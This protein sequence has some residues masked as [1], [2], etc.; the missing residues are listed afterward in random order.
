MIKIHNLGFPRIGE[1]RELKFALER[2]WRGELD[3]NELEQTAAELRARHWHTQANSGLDL[4]PVG[5]FSY[6]DH[7]LD[8]SIMLGVIP[9][10]F[11]INADIDTYFRMARG[12]G[13]DN[14]PYRALEMTKWFDTNYH[15]LVPEITAH[16]SFT[17]S[18]NKLFDET[19]EL[20]TLGY[21]A[22]P[23]L[24]GPLTW[25]WLAKAP[26]D[27]NKLDLLAKLLPVYSE[28]LCRLAEQGVQWVQIDE[29]ILV[30]DLPAAWK[31]AFEAVYNHLQSTPIKLL[32][33][34]YFGGV[35]ELTSFVCK[36]PVAGLHI[37]CI[38]AP[39][40]L[41]GVL[42]NLANHKVL[43][44][45]VIDGRN[46]WRTDLSS[47][48]NILES[49]KQRF[50]GELWLAPSCSLL[51][52]PIDLEYETALNPT[53]KYW[54][55]FAKQKLTEL[56]VLRNAVAEPSAAEADLIASACAIQSRRES[57]LSHNPA[58]QAELAKINN[59]LTQRQ[60]PFSVRRQQ[61]HAKLNL[62]SYPTTTIGSFPQ[63]PDIRKAR[64]DFKRGLLSETDYI[65]QMQHSIEFCI[66]EQEQLG[67][68]VLVHGEAERNDMVEYFGEQLEGFA[69]TVN[70][71]V[72]SY[73][74]RCVKPPIIYGDVS[75][76]K[77]ITVRWSQYAQSLT[78]KPMKGMLTGPVTLLNWS[79]CS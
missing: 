31:N 21:Q 72:Q 60:S 74:S 47:V 28:I 12:Q 53:I 44:L 9:E 29:P 62:P 4:I 67:L 23:V 34:T 27:V 41:T 37:D 13:R 71:W 70:G 49:V 61:Q 79:F 56:A 57:S 73:G 69:F 54:L 75:R 58:V 52:V 22:K 8:T 14:Q 10:R 66:R 35:D 36:L 30:L 43:S 17:L 65:Q 25:L 40:Q 1:H 7:V 3:Q 39:G 15:Y 45:G 64:A 51:H 18:S 19:R 46:I 26:D 59:S 50:T 2:Y 42:D 11:G 38:R 48:L 78:D 5:D 16:Q 76:P 32:L 6:Y 33:T 63:T 55:A 20:Q 77:P 24:L 68:D